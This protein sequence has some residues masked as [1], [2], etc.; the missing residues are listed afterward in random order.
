MREVRHVRSDGRTERRLVDFGERSA[1][2]PKAET[3]GE[4]RLVLAGAPAWWNDPDVF[5]VNEVRALG[6][7]G[8]KV[9]CPRRV[10]RSFGPVVVAGAVDERTI[11][12]A[13]PGDVLSWAQAVEYGLVTP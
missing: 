9:V 11:C 13:T 3:I 2:A 4:T 8:V 12:V 10:V 1:F 6:L 5:T 7:T